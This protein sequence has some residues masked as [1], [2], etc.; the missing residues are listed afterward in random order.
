MAES[1]LTI[2]SSRQSSILEDA[3][4][5]SDRYS[6]DM[7]YRELSCDNDL[8]TAAVYKRNF[9]SRRLVKVREERRKSKAT[10]S[11]KRHDL[12]KP[13]NLPPDCGAYMQPES[14]YDTLSI[15]RLYAESEATLSTEHDSI[16]PS[17]PHNKAALHDA[18][19]TGD[20]VL[21]RKLLKAELSVAACVRGREPLHLTAM[22][23][24]ASMVTFLLQNG[25]NAAAKDDT[26]RQP[27]HEACKAN[28]IE[29]A[30][31][32]LDGGANVNSPGASGYTPL[33]YVSYDTDNPD[34]A[35]LLLKHGADIEAK[36]LASKRPLELALV[37]RHCQVAKVLILAG[38]NPND[39]V[40]LP[41]LTLAIQNR[42]KETGV[43][44]LE[45]GADIN[46]K[47]Q[48]GGTV[49]HYM[50][51]PIN[52]I[53]SRWEFMDVLSEHGLDFRA[54]DNQGNEPL[55]CI[56]QSASSVD[57]RKLLDFF[58]RHGAVLDA[59]N[60]YGETPLYIAAKQAKPNIMRSL[61]HR[62]ATRLSREEKMRL[63]TRF[64]GTGQTFILEFM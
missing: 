61:M 45:Y 44:L 3:D 51:L 6:E 33:H 55:H 46:A 26:G 11:L 22:A 62:G 35:Q 14:T 18:A 42:L 2:A 24:H 36:T 38:A 54:R 56:V 29:V 12:E 9:W 23:G 30:R 7:V 17:P 21:A 25:A 13:I 47:N 63:L 49:L 27:I 41:P 16:L 1:A 31:I 39:T 64:H 50:T 37:S 20:I 34:L 58:L 43:Q 59:R 10:P 48:S 28:S 40:Q 15:L 52:R 19:Q 53:S 5:F 32:L 8:F 4:G 57:F 60:N